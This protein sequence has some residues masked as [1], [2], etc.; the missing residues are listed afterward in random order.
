[1]K[2][3][4]NTFE[5]QNIALSA[6][7]NL[8]KPVDSCLKQIHPLENELLIILFY[9][10]SCLGKTTFSKFMQT[11]A[12]KKQISFRKVTLDSI[13]GPILKKFKETHLDVT[14]NEEIFFNCWAEIAAQFKEGI[15]E[16]IARCKPGKNILFI[17]DG[18]LDPQV[19]KQ[20]ES[21]NLLT[22]H[23][24]KLLAIYPQKNSDFVINQD[25]MIPFSP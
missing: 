5:A 14:D 3:M 15:F 11:E 21:P 25:K 22:T 10:V 18:K 7:A 4:N 6:C 12:Q 23:T 13:G 17:D 16:E 8:A 20:L 24:V 19:L 2:S 1:M 9:G